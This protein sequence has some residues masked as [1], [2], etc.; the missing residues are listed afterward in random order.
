MTSL[1]LTGDREGPGAVT[2]EEIAGLPGMSNIGGFAE[3]AVGDAVPAAAVVA[4]ARPSPGAAFCS[5]VSV[6]GEYTASIP[7]DDL[8][9]GGWLAFRLAGDPLPEA[10]GGP[11]RL[12]VAQGRTLCWNVKNVGELRFTD[13]KEPDSVPTRPKH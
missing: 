8:V 13:A 6:D 10:D 9:D 11:I 2:L 4:L 1:L 3:H 5:V 12:T 7:L